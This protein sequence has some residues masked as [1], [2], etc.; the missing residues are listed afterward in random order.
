M[1]ECDNNMQ[2]SSKNEIFRKQGNHIRYMYE[3]TNLGFMS[4]YYHIR[5]MYEYTNLGFMSNYYKLNTD[6]GSG[7]S[8]SSTVYSKQPGMSSLIPV[9]HLHYDEV[10]EEILGH[11]TCI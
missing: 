7:R 2:I 8:L 10:R 6:Q 3:Y 4:N 1:T 5:Y 11:H 9:D